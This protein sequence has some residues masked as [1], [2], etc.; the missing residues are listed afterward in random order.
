ME[1]GSST[2]VKGFQFHFMGASFIYQLPF[3]PQATLDIWPS[4]FLV[5]G[6]SSEEAEV[7]P[8]VPI[9]VKSVVAKPKV[10]T[11]AIGGEVDTQAIMWPATTGLSPEGWSQSLFLKG[12]T[13]WYR[14]VSLRVKR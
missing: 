12:N 10:V 3:V 6:T 2:H 11:S 9:S 4:P 7:T 14:C 5:D 8:K 13:D 1:G